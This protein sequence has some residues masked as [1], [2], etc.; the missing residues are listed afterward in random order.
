MELYVGNLKQ[1][2]IFERILY[3]MTGSDFKNYLG[4]SQIICWVLIIPSHLNFFFFLIWWAL[5]IERCCSLNFSRGRGNINICNNMLKSLVKYWA[6]TSWGYIL[7]YLH[8]NCLFYSGYK[9]NLRELL[10]FSDA[11]DKNWL[12]NA[13]CFVLTKLYAFL[14]FE[15]HIKIRPFLEWKAKGE[16][17]F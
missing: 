13:G 3:I 4:I 15:A 14:L 5:S 7:L 10:T 11:T 1:L 9:G 12:S 16:L 6:Q 2:L 17:N 8:L